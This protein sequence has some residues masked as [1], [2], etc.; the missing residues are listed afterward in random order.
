MGKRNVQKICLC[1]LLCSIVNTDSFATWRKPDDI[2]SF[3]QV[4]R[5]DRRYFELSNGRPYVP[6]GLN[7][8]APRGSSEKEALATMEQWMRSLSE[9]RGNYIRIWLSHNFF[10][11]EHERSG[12]TMPTRPNALMPFLKWPDDTISVSR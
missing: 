7:M 9:N 11:V 8:I 1:C 5:Q 4:S 3:V 2:N 6:I 12:N 10:D